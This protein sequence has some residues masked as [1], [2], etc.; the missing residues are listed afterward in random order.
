MV[1]HSGQGEK[2]EVIDPHELP[3]GEIEKIEKQ[4]MEISL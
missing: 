4:P 1:D 2:F 3:P